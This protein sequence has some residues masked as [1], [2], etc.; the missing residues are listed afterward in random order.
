MKNI[1]VLILMLLQFNGWSQ[2]TNLLSG[3]YSLTELKNI[4]IPLDQWKP[5][6]SI[7][8]REGWSAADQ[9]MMRG[10]LKEAEGYLHYSWPSI[11]ATASLLIERTGDRQTHERFEYPLIG[12]VINPLPYLWRYRI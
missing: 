3:K 12:F 2:S 1:F 8:D 6:P 9:D 7:R 5:F 11:P 4:L 10:Y